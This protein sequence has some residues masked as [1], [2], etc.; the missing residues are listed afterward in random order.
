[1]DARI[2]SLDARLTRVE[3]T[4][5]NEIRDGMKLLA[6]GQATIIDQLKRMNG[7]PE[8]VEV[9]EKRADWHESEIRELRKAL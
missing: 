9:L 1:M 3:I 5:E 7:V 2:D 4:I 6:E 8:R